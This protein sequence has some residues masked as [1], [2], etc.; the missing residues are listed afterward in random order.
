M[1]NISEDGVTTSNTSR[2]TTDAVIVKPDYAGASRD[3]EFDFDSFIT[4]GV[5]ISVTTQASTANLCTVLLIKDTAGVYTDN[6]DLGTVTTPQDITAP[7][8]E[9]HLIFTLCNGHPT[10]PI[11]A[12]QNSLNLG[13]GVNDGLDTQRVVGFAAQDNASTSNT[14]SYIGNTSVTGQTFASVQSWSG[15]VSNYDSSGFTI[16]TNTSASGDE[17]VYL[18]IR[19]SVTP[20]LD[21]FDITIPTSGDYVESG[22]GFQPDF[23]FLALVDGPSSRNT[24]TAVNTGT[25][26]VTVLD[27]TNAYSSGIS[28]E[29]GIGIGVAKVAKGLTNNK[30]KH[31]D[32][33]G[34]ALVDS[35]GYSL[36]SNGWTFTLTTSPSSSVLGYGLAASFPQPVTVNLG[37]ATETDSAAEVLIGDKE[38]AIEVGSEVSIANTIEPLIPQGVTVEDTFTTTNS[39]VIRGTVELDGSTVDLVVNGTDNYSTKSLSGVYRIPT[40]PWEVAVSEVFPAGPGADAYSMEPML[41]ELKNGNILSV[42][43]TGSTHANNDGRLLGRISTDQGDTWGT[44]FTIYDSPTGFDTRN[45][46][47]GV[48]PATGRVVIFTRIYDADTVTTVDIGYLTSDDHGVTWSDFTSIVD[49]FSDSSTG[50]ND[51]L[52]FGPMVRTANGLM[53]AFY[54]HRDCW[55]LFSKDGGLTWGD[56]VV[57][58]LGWP[59]PVIGEPRAIAVDQ[60]RLVL[61]IRDNTIGNRNGY[62][63]V[64]SSD[65]GKT[66]T[67][68][69]AVFDHMTSVALDAAAPFNGIRVEDDLISAWHTRA[70]D[71]KMYTSRVNIEDFFDDPPFAWSETA[72]NRKV[73]TNAVTNISI[74]WGYPNFFVR[75]GQEYTALMHWYDED[76]T[77]SS[78]VS[79]HQA[80]FPR[81]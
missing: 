18:A 79:I 19:F 68:L 4:D 52:A 34:S 41:E 56:K 15:V 81:L 51:V 53:Q 24:A 42:V 14:T 16:Q 60:H 28:D 69:S 55:V 8:F 72:P 12:T 80:T 1:A 46:A 20:S 11:T 67:A 31:L 66:W 58:Y 38:I 65:G 10:Y 29:D 76:L 13:I 27:D 70:P 6:H 43:R 37:T 64:K 5:R 49:Q 50:N 62:R 26:G 21:L 63:F 73:V 30:F 47:G 39:P 33:S 75:E 71:F 57:V 44:V 77:N 54:H 36:D 78:R 2:S 32:A 59:N 9:P 17:L 48:D 74:D 25:L 61:V 22:L 40:N 45:Q 35:S 7:G 3:F 23:G